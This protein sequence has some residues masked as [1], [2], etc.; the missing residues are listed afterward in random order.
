MEAWSFNPDFS[1]GLH[2][3][4]VDALFDELFPSV[5]NNAKRGKLQALKAALLTLGQA[6]NDNQ[7]G[8]IHGFIHSRTTSGKPT[9]PRYKVCDF[10][11][12]TFTE[13][14]DVLKEMK[15]LVT[16]RSG[17]KS[18]DQR[19]GVASL[20]Q[21]T[22][23]FSTW[24]DDNIKDLELI[25]F[26][27][28]RE[29]VR[30]KHTKSDDKE[31][32]KYYEDTQ[33]TVAMRERLKH[34]NQVRQQ[35]T[36]DYLPLEDDRQFVLDDKRQHVPPESLECYRVFNGDFTSGGR[37]YCGIQSLRKAERG[38]IEANGLSTIELDFKSLHPRFL[39]NMEGLD[40]PK[41]C[42]ASPTGRDR[43]LTKF[44]S[45]LCINCSNIKQACSALMAKVRKTDGMTP[46]NMK[47]YAEAKRHIDGYVEEHPLISHRFF[48]SAWMELQYLDSQL[49]DL[50]LERA[51][52]ESIA[53]LPVHDSFIVATMYVDWLNE[54]TAD[55]YQTLMGFE[56]V[57]AFDPMPDLQDALPE[58][59]YQSLRHLL[60]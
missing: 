32:L 6:S 14:L 36:W 16:H 27:D 22:E 34:G 26:R 3:E 44:I 2:G 47:D 54:A 40:A 57:I 23:A 56:P 45:L 9:L 46:F 39:Y 48:K 43:S 37:F 31:G 11:P 20:W 19:Q 53:V 55:A 8:R 28:T 7:C 1:H 33:L 4:A 17:F 10:K 38:T 59:L 29:L 13:V 50:V 24:L 18:K 15:G 41:D 58:E 21:P 52:N 12:R 5:G 51:N 42:Y 25:S 49:V 35:S 30:L 60:E